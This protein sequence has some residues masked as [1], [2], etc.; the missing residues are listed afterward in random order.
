M[1]GNRYAHVEFPGA[2]YP[3]LFERLS[4]LAESPQSK[5]TLDYKGQG[6]HPYSSWYVK[7]HE[8]LE[9]IA[10]INNADRMAKPIPLLGIDGFEC[11]WTDLAVQDTWNTPD[12]CVYSTGTIEDLSFTVYTKG[13]DLENQD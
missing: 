5:C 13:Y 4:Q 12:A 10:Q 1:D 6:E 9:I 3:A 11:V 8:L 7:L 2:E